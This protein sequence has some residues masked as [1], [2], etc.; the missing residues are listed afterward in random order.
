[1]SEQGGT[2]LGG[3]SRYMQEEGLLDQGLVAVLKEVDGSL[4]QG[5]EEVMEGCHQHFVKVLNI[6][7]DYREE[8]I[9]EMPMLPL[10]TKL[11]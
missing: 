6:P 5:P 3:C 9:N 7:S 4:T 11:D 1:M 8:A 2:V 10:L